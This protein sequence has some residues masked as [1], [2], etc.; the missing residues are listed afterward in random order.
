MDELKN[1]C[2]TT[3]DKRVVTAHFKDTLAINARLSSENERLKR[4]INDMAH[5]FCQ[6]RRDDDFFKQVRFSVFKFFVLLTLANL[7]FWIFNGKYY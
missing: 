2:G 1:C 3:C 4:Q 5:S 7:L 6:N